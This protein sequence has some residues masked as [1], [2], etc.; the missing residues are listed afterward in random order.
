MLAVQWSCHIED[1]DG[2]VRH[3]EFLDL[4]GEPPMRAL[5]E[6]LIECLGTVGPVLM[7][8]SY[9]RT[10]INGLVRLFPDLA[11]E[12]R[13]IADRLVDLF[14][15]VKKHYYH[16][17]MLGSWS[18]KAV[19]PA[20]V[21]GMSYDGLEGINEGM[22]AADGFLEAIDTGTD[23]GRK[24]ELEGELLRYCR[25]DTEAMVGIVRY[26]GAA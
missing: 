21:P 25:F 15:I 8:T 24:L 5:A 26:L 16:P 6:R 19:L 20:M 22:G 13:A 9:E 23:R 11:E 10:V 4:S 12:L 17:Q 14:P 18:I 2:V 1:E 7:Y 3:E